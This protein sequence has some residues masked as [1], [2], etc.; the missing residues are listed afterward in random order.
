MSHFLILFALATISLPLFCSIDESALLLMDAI[1]TQDFG[2]K[3][4]ERQRASM[5][6]AT[7]NQDK[8]LRVMT[9][10]MLYNVKE[11]EDKLPLKHRWDYRRPRL[12][13][14]LSFANA[15][16]IGSQELQEDQ[17]EEI[18]NFLGSSY[19]YYG[20]KTRENEGRS[21]INAIFFKKNRVEL[22]ESKT[23]PYNDDHYENAFVYCYFRDKLQDKKFVV[24]NTKLTWGDVERR[25]A[26]ATQLNQF[27]NLLSS[28]EPIIILGDFNTFPFT[29]HERNMFFDGDHIEQVLAGKNLKDARIK[30]AFGHFGPICSIT[31]SKETLEPFTGPQLSGFI[32]D[33]IFIND[34]I[35][36]FTHGIDT[37]KVEGE[38]PS[39][40]FPVIAD[41]H[42]R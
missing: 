28:E 29:Q 41:L 12:L 38:F 9:Y 13:E 21:D 40:H 22:I 8:K 5:R 27:S 19:G 35:E 4:N 10:N 14:Y 17:V 3:V 39:D 34:H 1:Y 42:L 36:V 16:I 11:A 20:K 32:L 30:S 25:L 15:D 7:Q 33:H 18:M 26:E 23:I 37:A 24:I 6:Y 2:K 31:N